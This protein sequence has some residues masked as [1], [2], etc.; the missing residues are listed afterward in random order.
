MQF[1]GTVIATEAVSGT[2][3]D[4]KVTVQLAS[5]GSGFSFVTPKAGFAVGDDVTIDIVKV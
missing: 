1:T 2:K 4:V 3:A 5:T